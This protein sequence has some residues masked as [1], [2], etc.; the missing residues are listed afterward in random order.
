[1]IIKNFSVLR[2]YQIL[3]IKNKKIKDKFL[4]SKPFIYKIH[5]TPKDY[6][7]FTKKI[8]EE[9]LRVVGFK[10]IKSTVLKRDLFICI[11]S[12]YFNL[13]RFIPLTNIF[14]LSIS[15]FLDKFTELF[16]DDYK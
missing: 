15:L 16:S 4:G 9:D 1:M 6:F 14:L 11:Y 8:L 12:S 10:K 13:T 7:P 3:E 2:I 5:G